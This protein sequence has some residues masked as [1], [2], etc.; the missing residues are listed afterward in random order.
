M[1]DEGLI[2]FEFVDY[3]LDR[4]AMYAA[5]FIRSL[6]KESYMEAINIL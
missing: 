4:V 1:I 5:A 3:P 6:P 2:Q